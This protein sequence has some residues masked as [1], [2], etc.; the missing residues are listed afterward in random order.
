MD[1]TRLSVILIIFLLSACGGGGGSNNTS[2]D[3]DDQDEATAETAFPDG[4][5][6]SSPF[7]FTDEDIVL[8]RP[9][10]RS[11]H[12][13]GHTSRYAWA[14]ARIERLLQGDTPSICRF[15]PE[16]FLAQEH[17]AECY[18]PN[19]AYEGHPDFDPMA[20]SGPFSP[21]E[22]GE[23]PSGDVG[24]WAET[25]DDTGNACAAAQLNARMEGIRDRS[26][27]SL[28]GL[29]A[30]ICT[31]NVNS[32]SMPSLSTEVLTDEMNDL[33]ISDTSFTV[34][35][36]SHTQNV[37]SE[38]VYSYRLDMLYTP[39][40][41]PYRIIVE[42]EHTVGSTVGAYSGNVSF[43]IDDRFSG[44]NCPDADI[45]VNGSLHYERDS[46]T[47]MRAEVRQGQFCGHGV[48]GLTADNEVDAGDKYD[49]GTNTDGWGNNFSIFTLDFNPRNLAGDYAYNWQA[50]PNDDNTRA[51]NVHVEYDETSEATT[52][53]AFYGFGDD[54]ETTDGS[55]KGFICNWAGPG[56]DH[57]LLDYAQYQTLTYDLSTGIVSADVSNIVY[58]PTTSCEY[59]GTGTFS[60]DSDG[61]GSVDTDTATA[62]NLDLL[63]LTD[64]EPDSVWDEIEASGFE[65]PEL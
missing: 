1:K 6:I 62:V 28:S 55:V 20:P 56:S 22:D 27:A 23:L 16:S 43:R 39:A 46:N 35:S 59:D 10:V 29:A 49:S 15:S 4:L 31:A 51:F 44:G 2:D 17:D 63:S 13:G 11:S 64:S 53:T 30:M 41:Q 50:G 34:A 7:D 52:A 54:I 48:N 21:G 36:I 25:D 57:T 61:D 12:G 5:A 60:Y 32:I 40:T 37:D 42:M 58:A 47:E 26:L 33:G 14:T 18:G 3:D 8:A 19:V 45:T 65:L 24:M 38:D 9:E